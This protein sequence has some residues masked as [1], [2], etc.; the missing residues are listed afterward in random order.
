MNSALRR[1]GY[2]KGEMT[3]HGFRSM[4]ARF[5]RAR[6]EFGCDRT[7]ARARRARLVA[8]YNHAEHLAEQR[9]SMQAWADSRQTGRNRCRFR[10]SRCICRRVSDSG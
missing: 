6:L 9:G 3:A 5:E 10:R 8:A 4:A 2:V 7:P 1:M